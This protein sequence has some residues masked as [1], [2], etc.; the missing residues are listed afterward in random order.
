[1]RKSK[2]RSVRYE[3]A[4]GIS[5]KKMAKLY[6]AYS[7]KYSEFADSGFTRSD[8]LTKKQF[9]DYIGENWKN[10]K[11]SGGDF[12]ASKLANSKFREQTTI[13]MGD[14]DI[15]GKTAKR[16][17]ESYSKKYQAAKEKLGDRMYDDRMLT[18]DEYMAQRKIYKEAG[19]T[20][21][22]NRQLVTDQS[23]EYTMTNAMNIRD[24][25]EE[26]GLEDIAQTPIRD[27]MSGEVDLSSGGDNPSFLT[28]LNNALKNAHPDWNGY[29]RSDF[30]AHSVFGS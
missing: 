27:I 23:Y 4:Y 21:N 15:S 2:M 8:K 26:Y 25:A 9:R 7:K 11:E 1:M 14:S 29:Y 24:I 6:K 5:S 3:K 18:F 28:D 20:Q 19:I 22:V 10:A 17:Y 30:I 12:S 16:W 13:R